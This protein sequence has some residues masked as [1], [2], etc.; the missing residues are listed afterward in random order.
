LA[1]LGRVPAVGERVDVDDLE[2]EV[3]EAERRRVNKV[4]VRKREAVP[5]R[6]QG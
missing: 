2:I 1:R 6:N 4:R 5:D 3:L